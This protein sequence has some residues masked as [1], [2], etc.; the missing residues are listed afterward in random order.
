MKSI[1]HSSLEMADAKAHDTRGPGASSLSKP[2]GATLD[3]DL[4][5][6]YVVIAFVYVLMGVLLLTFYILRQR[7]KRKK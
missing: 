3:R 2:S 6:G 4:A 5:E 7:S 1:R